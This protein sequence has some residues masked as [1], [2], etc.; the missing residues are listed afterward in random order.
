VSVGR[1]RIAMVAAS[2]DIVG[3]QGVQAR[4]LVDALE[5]DGFDVTFVAIDRRFPR[6]LC[7]ARRIRG[8]RTVINQ[9][10]YVPSLVALSW[11]DVVHVFSASYWSF[12]LAPVPAMIAGRLF[13]ARV[14]LHY[15]S[16]E[17]DDHLAH[18]GTLVHPWLRL[19]HEIVVPS[20][21][22]RHVFARFGYEARVV[23]N[24]VDVT[25]FRYRERS[26]LAPRLLCARNLD[27]YYRVDLVIEAFA[28][29]RALVPEAT[30]TIAGYG[31]EEARMRRLA[32][33]VGG[34]AVQ[35]AGKVDP[36]A[37]PAL[38]DRHD[39]FVNASELD[40]QPVSILEAFAAGLPVVT[41]AAGDIP[42][43][44]RNGE[45]GWVVPVGDVAALAAALQYAWQHPNVARQ[46]ARRAHEALAEHSWPHVREQWAAV[47]GH[48]TQNSQNTQKN[49]DEIAIV[50]PR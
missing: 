16:G 39:I 48:R 29:F 44:V 21:Y 14:V 1:P 35:F 6:W 37:M 30:L 31:A 34:D 12:L 40:N 8:L 5:R 18:W 45:G 47:Y 4:S 19:A 3:G 26:P 43:M 11:V 42:A 20:A 25:Q 22:L 17:A 13:G 9:L 50:Q 33:V 24:I 10:L 15:H 23:P 36:A 2:L 49:I 32:S 38:Y 7:W 41:T 28:H 27:R 46:R